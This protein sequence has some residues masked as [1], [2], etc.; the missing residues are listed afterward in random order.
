[1]GE[2]A[3]MYEDNYLAGIGE[4]QSE[5]ILD[6]SLGRLNGEQKSK[7]PRHM[8]SGRFLCSANHPMPKDAEGYWAH[9]DAS[10]VGEQEDGYPGVGI[11]TMQCLNCKL[12]W[13]LELPQ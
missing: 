13:R 10:E 8:A 4:D 9:P 2:M 11:V 5:R 3:D 7:H 6:Y 1:M 12:R